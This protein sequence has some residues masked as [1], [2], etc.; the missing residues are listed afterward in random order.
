VDRCLRKDAA[1]RFASAEDL[2]GELGAA[3]GALVQVP[4]ALVRFSEDARAVGVEVGT[5]V[6]SSAALIAVFETIKAIEG[7]FLGITTAIEV[8]GVAALVGLTASQLGQLVGQVREL[9]RAGYDHR[10]LVAA[11]AL[12][13]REPAPETSPGRRR[14]EATLTAAAGLSVTAVGMAILR[15]GSEVMPVI[16][17]ALSVAAPA[18]TVRRLWTRFG[19]TRL[20]RRLLAGRLGRLL[21]RVGGVGVKNVP[22]LPAVG[23]HTEVALGRAAHALYEELPPAVR[24]TLGDVPALLARLESD[25]RALRARA[26]DPGGERRLASAVAAL[27]TLRLDLLRLKVG[28]GTLDELTANVEAAR[29]VGEEVD[30]ALAATREL[31][32]LAE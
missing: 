30:A 19:G 17:F 24:H 1:D 2:V 10:A 29:R 16:G 13:D 28:A 11:F 8:L 32:S 22:A 25:A 6:G 9:K 18:L 4:A 21:F 26:G 31:K 20:W 23:E 7:D 5:Y 15:S 14:L 12:Q 3:R 27:E